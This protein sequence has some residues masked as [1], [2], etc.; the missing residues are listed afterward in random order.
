MGPN[1]KHLFEIFPTF[2]VLRFD[3]NV[4]EIV[5]R[6]V[7]K[8]KDEHEFLGL[9]AVPE[10]NTPSRVL[11]SKTL[12]INNDHEFL[13]LA[14]VPEIKSEPSDEDSFAI[15][16]RYHGPGP[17][18]SKPDESI[19]SEIS[20]TEGEFVLKKEEGMVTSTPKPQVN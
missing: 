4:S 18:S 7:A 8:I 11:V 2:K 20:F 3:P 9:A 1:Q 13:G 14:E 12:E 6:P 5:E 16:P 15:V 17:S 19:R 10:I